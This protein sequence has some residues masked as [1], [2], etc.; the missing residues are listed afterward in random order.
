[1]TKEPT[2]PE[3][4][5]LSEFLEMLI[6]RQKGRSLAEIAKSADISS[7]YFHLLLSGKRKNPSLEILN[8]LADAFR[9]TEED[10]RALYKSA[11]F[12]PDLCEG[13]IRDFYSGDFRSA[14]RP[15]TSADTAAKCAFRI[16][17]EEEDPNR[18][19]SIEANPDHYDKNTRV[20]FRFIDHQNHVFSFPLIWD[21]TITFTI[22]SGSHEIDIEFIY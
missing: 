11:G 1:M 21:E 7:T 18:R 5:S 10:R 20:R 17:V 19:I 3:S 4:I 8:K 16:H 9:L 15:D 22:P 2:N 12:G 6:E 14:S 13:N